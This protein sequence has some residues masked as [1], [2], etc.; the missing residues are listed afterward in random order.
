MRSGP[1]F[2]AVLLLGLASAC[3]PSPASAQAQGDAASARIAALEARLTALEDNRDIERLFRAYGYYFDKGLWK[4]T[5]T[6]FTDD[7]DVEIAQRGVYRGRS[8]VERLYVQI[9][10]KG[11]NCLPPNGLNNHMILQPIMTVNPDG[12]TASGRA[13]II[14]MLA[15]RENDFM[16]QEGLYNLQFR[17]DGGIWRIRSLHYFGDIYAIVPG[18]LKQYA[19]PQSSASS[20]VAPDAP[21]TVRY[22]SYP[23]YYLPEF[24]YPN[25]VTGQVVDTAQCNNAASGKMP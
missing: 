20:D 1:S 23:G 4:E 8:S 21:P 7:A 16:L 22:P 5:T 13:R 10:G 19:V 25:P 3:A 24:P 9:F 12:K 14:G 2:A 17:K 6:L 11:R 18:A 15:I